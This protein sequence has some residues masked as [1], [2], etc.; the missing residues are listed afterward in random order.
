MKLN[1]NEKASALRQEWQ[2]A[3]SQQVLFLY[4]VTKEGKEEKLGETAIERQI[5]FGVCGVVAA[6]RNNL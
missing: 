4:P 3:A 2:N 5:G 6:S 1:K